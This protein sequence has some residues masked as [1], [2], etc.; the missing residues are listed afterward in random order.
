MI[1]IGD[2]V[3]TS[4]G[5]GPF[6]VVEI[7]RDCDCPSYLA[8]LKHG[9]MNGKAP[10]SK[11]HFH[12]TLVRADCPIG[13]EPSRGGDMKGYYWINGYAE[14]GGRY[15]SV[16]SKDELFVEGKTAGVQLKLF[17]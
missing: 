6:R 2:I 10:R 11:P 4:Y 3:R 5:T 14:Q 9:F 1:E 12:L 17:A 13:K 15:L 16:W 7:K 8:E